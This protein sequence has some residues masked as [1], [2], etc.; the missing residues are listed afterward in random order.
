MENTNEDKRL[1]ELNG[2]KAEIYKW[3]ID[4]LQMLNEY[5]IDGN[6]T[7]DNLQIRIGIFKKNDNNENIPEQFSEDCLSKGLGKKTW[8]EYTNNFAKS[9]MGKSIFNASIY[10]Q[11]PP[12]NLFNSIKNIDNT[13]LKELIDKEAGLNTLSF[14]EITGSLE[15]VL[16]NAVRYYYVHSLLS[17]IIKKKVVSKIPCIIISTGSNDAGSDY[18]L[19]LYICSGIV[20]EVVDSFY[21]TIIN[22]WNKPSDKLFDTN[23]YTSAY[24]IPLN[25]VKGTE[26]YNIMKVLNEMSIISND[27]ASFIKL[28]C[29]NDY[30]LTYALYHLIETTPIERM[31]YTLSLFEEIMDKVSASKDIREKLF[32]NIVN[33]I[34]DMMVN[35]KKYESTFE[36][37]QENTQEIN[38]ECKNIT[39]MMK[40]PFDFKI[41]EGAIKCIDNNKKRKLYIFYTKILYDKLK[42]PITDKELKNPNIANEKMLLICNLIAKINICMP[43]TYYTYGALM[44]GVAI[45]QMKINV[46]NDD[47]PYV[48]YACS[49]LEDYAFIMEKYGLFIQDESNDIITNINYIGKC[50]KYAYR[51]I[52]S[53]Y[54]LKCK[55]MNHKCTS[56]IIQNIKFKETNIEEL[57]LA[58]DVLKLKMF[59]DNPNDEGAIHIY[60]TIIDTKEVSEAKELKE[61]ERTEEKPIN[62]LTFLKWLDDRIRETN[63]KIVYEGSYMYAIAKKY[64]SDYLK[65]K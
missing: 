61:T 16:M 11:K 47:T 52:H 44:M 39:A 17:E 34:A 12:I 1:E 40:T 14:E 43:E 35:S 13:K 59:K 15:L 31:E 63:K 5:V 4:R 48:V 37:V 25:S 65:L 22:H 26:C 23:I 49:L 18:D 21:N 46:I 2:K 53:L 28:Y 64:K 57:K 55:F 20:S 32:N 7:D 54:M 27:Y 29:E 19:G 9:R 51:I 38:Q 10:E 24:L 45:G 56:N 41:L 62:F 33:V 50:A 36:N 30:Q 3:Y 58:N 8:V 60:R 42:E 6:I